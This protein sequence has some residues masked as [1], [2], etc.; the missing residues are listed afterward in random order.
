MKNRPRRRTWTGRTIGLALSCLLIWNVQSQST[1]SQSTLYETQGVEQPPDQPFQSLL[2]QKTSAAVRSLLSADRSSKTDAL[3]GS[4]SEQH[5]AF[6]QSPSGAWSVDVLI[7]SDAPYALE[8]MGADVLAVVGR[9]VAARVPV[10]TLQRVVEAPSVKYVDLSRKGR[11]MSANGGAAMVRAG[12]QGISQAGDVLVGL[13]DTGIDFTH[14]DLM[15]STG[16]RILYLWDMSDVD[17]TEAP[18]DVDPAFNWGRQ[19][20][21]AHIDADPN[22]VIQRDGDGGGGHGTHVAGIAAGSGEIDTANQGVA[23]GANLIVVKALRT[24]ESEGGFSE[25]DVLA[26][27]DYILKQAAAM[28]KPVVI[29]LSLGHYNGP[30]DGSSLFE[31]ALSELSGPGRILVAAAGN[32]GFKPIHAGGESAS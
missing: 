14:P 29:N 3:P 20:T 16:T 5:Y 8:D 27:C 13:V 6:Q 10:N 11:P 26:A 23:P 22:Q 4:L 18:T 1:S 24:V 9:I 21:K 31:E 17:N 32:G 15:D 2:L 19:Y 12:Y 30:L 7:E 25:A 28:G